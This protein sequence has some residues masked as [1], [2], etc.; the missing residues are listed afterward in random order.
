LTT[1]GGEKSSQFIQSS[2]TR[3]DRFASRSQLGVWQEKCKE[4]N[5]ERESSVPGSRPKSNP[6]SAGTG[7]LANDRKLG[8]KDCAELSGPAPGT[9]TPRSK[10]RKLRKF[11]YLLITRALRNPGE[12]Q[13]K[14][15]SRIQ[16]RQ[17]FLREKGAGEWARN[18]ENRPNPA[19]KQMTREGVG[20]TQKSNGHLYDAQLRG[21][22]RGLQKVRESRIHGVASKIVAKGRGEKDYLSLERRDP[23]G[24][25]P[26]LHGRL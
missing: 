3:V 12:A 21:T 23:L 13:K 8:R 17:R 9:R 14:L 10:R 25:Q 1:V 24:L 22:K 4:S 16:T 18:E 11:N 2:S 7:N 19:R 20:K 15:E 5:N 26:P 6:C